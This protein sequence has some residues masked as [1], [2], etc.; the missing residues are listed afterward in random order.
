MSLPLTGV[1]FMMR[2]TASAT[3]MPV[4]AQ[5]QRTEASAASTSTRWYLCIDTSLSF[6]V[7]R[8]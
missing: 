6:A 3:R 7:F 1:G 5:L 2:W 8:C 4:T